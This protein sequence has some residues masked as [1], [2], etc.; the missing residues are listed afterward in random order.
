[1]TLSTTTTFAGLLESRSA[2]SSR[3]HAVAMP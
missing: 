2:R 1:M 3:E